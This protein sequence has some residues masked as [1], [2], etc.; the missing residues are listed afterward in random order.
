M[1]K[2]LNNTETPLIE[3]NNAALCSSGNETRLQLRKVLS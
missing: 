2:I 1:N 3:L